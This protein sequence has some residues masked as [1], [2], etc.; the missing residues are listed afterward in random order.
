VICGATGGFLPTIDLRYLWNKQ[1][2][3][4]GSHAGTY[5]EWS[6]CLNLVQQGRIRP[7][8]TKV[9]PLDELADAQRAMEGRQ[10]MGKLAI[11]CS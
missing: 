1:L 5:R 6:E 11:E 9:F 8:V 10:V 3:F 7:P 2:S 4:L